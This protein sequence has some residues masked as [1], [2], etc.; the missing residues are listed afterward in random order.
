MG[1]DTKVSE[2]WLYW[3]SLFSQSLYLINYR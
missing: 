1:Q 3:L 2:K